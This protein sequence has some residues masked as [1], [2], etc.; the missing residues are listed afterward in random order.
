M[1]RS[2]YYALKASIKEQSIII[3]SVLKT[4]MLNNLGRLFKTYLK[5]V[6]DRMRKDKKLEKNDVL[7][8]AIEEEKTCIKVDYKASA[9]IA[10]TKSNAKLQSGGAKERKEFVEWS[11]C[12]KC[13]HKHL[14][15]KICKHANE[16]C[17]KFHKKKHILCFHDSYI[18]LNKGKT[19]ERSATS[20]SDSKK[21]LPML[22]K[23]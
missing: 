23:W 21:T 8:K 6:N 14:A 12:K 13:G 4:Q 7:F 2:K 5:V 9:S 18:S 17:D 11:K 20:S 1:Y 3:E 19:Q 16:N 15:D 10:S 22:L